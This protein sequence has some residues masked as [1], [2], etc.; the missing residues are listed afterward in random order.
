MIGFGSVWALLAVITLMRKGSG[1]YCSAE[2]EP[3]PEYQGIQSRYCSVDKCRASSL[4]RRRLSRRVN[5]REGV[6]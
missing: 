3:R 1:S 6:P 4:R 5:R 2:G